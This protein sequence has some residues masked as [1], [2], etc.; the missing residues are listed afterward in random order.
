MTRNWIAMT[1][2]TPRVHQNQSRRPR[3]RNAGVSLETL[4]ARL[5]L[6]SVA[7]TP[8]SWDLNPQPLPP[9]VMVEMGSPS[10]GGIMR[11]HVGVDIVGNHIGTNIV[12]SHIGTNIVGNHIGTSSVAPSIIAII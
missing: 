3:H 12:G 11:K 5:S 9:G 10:L 2:R 7:L 4:E 6:S 8:R 1:S